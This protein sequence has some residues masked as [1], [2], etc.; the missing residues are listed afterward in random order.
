MSADAATPPKQE[1]QA[2]Y[3]GSSWDGRG[4]GGGGG[5]MG[6][7]LC[8]A[9]RLR[10]QYRSGIRQREHSRLNRS[11]YVCVCHI[12]RRSVCALLMAKTCTVADT[13]GREK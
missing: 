13:D 6:S 4:R 11:N 2:V 3:G 5:D 8:S 7:D 1:A 12:S 10:A 9:M